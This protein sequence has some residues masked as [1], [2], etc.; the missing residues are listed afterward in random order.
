MRCE[1]LK[2]ILLEDLPKRITC[3][4]CFYDHDVPRSSLIGAAVP[5]PVPVPVQVFLLDSRDERPL[6]VRALG[7][8]E[9]DFLSAANLSRF[10]DFTSW[11]DPPLLFLRLYP[12]TSKELFPA[13]SRGHKV[14]VTSTLGSACFNSLRHS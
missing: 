13:P 8:P 5:V 10:R 11:Y 12:Y 6:K 3:S 1:E 7:A 2:G 9:R 4:I 14:N